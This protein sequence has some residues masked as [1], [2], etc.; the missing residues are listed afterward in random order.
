MIA[1]GGVYVRPQ[2]AMGIYDK[3]TQKQKTNLYSRYSKRIISADTA[4]KVTEM[5]KAVNENGAR[6]RAKPNNLTGAGKTGTAQTGKRNNAGEEIYTS[7]IAAFT[8]GQP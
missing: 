3:N 1:N 4:K 8:R 7:C 2:I 5:L 6:G